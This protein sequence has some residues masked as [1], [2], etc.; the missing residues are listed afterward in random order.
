MPLIT[1]LSFDQLSDFIAIHLSAG[2][3]RLTDRA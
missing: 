2:R 1:D 3:G